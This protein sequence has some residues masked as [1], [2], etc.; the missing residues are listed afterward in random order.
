MTAPPCRSCAAPLQHTFVNL[1]MS[2]LSNAYL[3]RE[4]LRKMEPFYP[5]H[6]LVCERC[7]LVQ[8]EEVESPKNIFSSYAYFSSY[9]D[10]WLDHVRR[11]V[12]ETTKRFA[13]SAKSLV[14]EIASND[15]YL[16]QY[17][18]ANGV[19][20]LGIEPAQNVAE[21]AREKGISTLTK[22]FGAGVARELSTGGQSADL[23]VANNVLAHVPD[24][25][26][27]VDGLNVLLKPH[28]IIT[29]EV[30]HLVRLIEGR[31][32]DTIY[33]EHFSYFSLLALDG[34]F[35]KHGLT[36]FDVDQLSTHGGSLRLYIRHSGEGESAAG[37]P[38]Q[39]RL[40][41]VR[42]LESAAG[43]YS[44]KAYL[45]FEEKVRKTKRGLLEF[46]I[47]AKGRGK[48]VAA[49]GAPAKGNTLLNYCGVGKD[50]I[51]YTVDISPHKQGLFLPGTHIPILHP[52][53][54]RRTKPDYVLILP[55]NLREEIL[56]QLADVRR[57][58]S[59]FVL[60]IPSVEVLE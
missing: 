14:I 7:F 4:D 8:L 15:G 10:S 16:L 46:L 19:P 57:A 29:V 55:W 33:H 5:L 38:S 26:D 35:R 59:R 39:E 52:D 17:F 40:C 43:M 54:L 24:L 42:D 11:Y 3:S 12:E 25:N 2:P 9:S 34:V 6:A 20:V 53:E 23:I 58:G 36:V 31:Q 45:D 37:K 1:G 48:S 28:G 41:R 44:L 30:P 47:D 56:E 32:F 21:V 22:F 13:L 18:K 49:Y 60:P 51:E 27:F 50:F